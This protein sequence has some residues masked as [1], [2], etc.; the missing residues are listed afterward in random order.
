LG[1]CAIAGLLLAWQ[2]A[3]VRAMPN[4][5]VLFGAAGVAMLIAAGLMIRRLRADLVAELLGGLTAASFAFSSA[6]LATAGPGTSP[7]VVF[8]SFQPALFFAARL[9]VSR[10]V[11]D[12]YRQV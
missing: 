10:A 3:T 2:T 4:P 1:L 5:A 11:R 12:R 6:G 7:E 9:L 8:G